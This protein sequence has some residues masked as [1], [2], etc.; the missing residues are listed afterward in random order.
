MSYPTNF[1]VKVKREKKNGIV[2]CLTDSD[3][4]EGGVSSTVPHRHV[5]T[6]QIADHGN[7]TLVQLL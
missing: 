6:M 1:G 7:P 4:W 3:S 2:G 5:T